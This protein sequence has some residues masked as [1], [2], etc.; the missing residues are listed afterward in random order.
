[1]FLRGKLSCPVSGC[2]CVRGEQGRR[3]S[4]GRRAVSRVSLYTVVPA[5]FGGIHDPIDDQKEEE[6]R[7]QTP[8]TD[9]GSNFK[10]LR[11][12]AGMCYHASHSLVGAVDEGDE[13][14][15]YSIVPQQFP[16][17]FSVDAVE[18]LLVVDKV[19]V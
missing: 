15:W 7:Q 4:R 6:R 19:D 1:M 17:R 9:S 16:Q 2:G 18:C 10:T 3:Q 12:L 14:L 13:L 11:H 5:C 8:L